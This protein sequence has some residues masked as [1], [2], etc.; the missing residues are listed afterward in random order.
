MSPEMTS[1]PEAPDGPGGAGAPPF[2][3]LG[4]DRKGSVEQIALTLF[5]VVPFLAI[6]AAVPL[7]WG[8]G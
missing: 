2:G 8:W 1:A 4:G 3:T 7:A 6:L 5:I